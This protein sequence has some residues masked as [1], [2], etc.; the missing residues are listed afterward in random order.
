M[1]L[2]PISTI[3]RQLT[4]L[5]KDRFSQ[6]RLAFPKF[7]LLLTIARLDR[8]I[9]IYLLLWPTLWGLWVANEG[10]PGFH[11]FAV[12]VLGTVL[13]RSA[14][15]VINDIADR[16]FDGQVKRTVN[17]PLANGDLEIADAFIFLFVLLFLALVL[18]L[19]TNLLT[20]GLA[21]IAAFIA[22]IYPLMKRYTYLPQ[23]VLGLA[24]SMGIPMAFSATTGEVPQ[25]A[26]LM[27][28]ANLIWTVAYDTQYAM[29]DRDD[30][31]KLGL[32][33]SAI[34]FGD[35]DKPIIGVLQIAFIWIMVMIGQRLELSIF[36]YF[37][38]TLAVALLIYQQYLIKDRDRDRCFASFLN[39]HWVGLAIFSGIFLHYF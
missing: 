5:L 33:S 35:L 28:I 6:L 16:N 23:A 2:P 3:H 1:P 19:T 24:F 20:L 8:P 10:Y 15:C 31:L 32:K 4:I 36:F 21:V 12:F 27:L 7:P 11:L 22:A 14:G 38:L 29:I 9:G 26:W 30:D 34:L 39:N 37:G 17:R 18:V 13:T 25:I